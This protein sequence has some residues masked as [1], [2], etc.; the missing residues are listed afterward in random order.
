[1]SPGVNPAGTSSCSVHESILQNKGTDCSLEFISAHANIAPFKNKPVGSF[2]AELYTA[3]SQ[4][5]FCLIKA[6]MRGFLTVLYGTFPPSKT[7]HI[8]TQ[9]PQKELGVADC[10]HAPAAKA[11]RWECSSMEKQK[12]FEAV[13]PD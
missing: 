5:L 1:M 2:G 4:R 3:R 13:N 6:V 11:W 8:D 9:C 7:L 10:F 12:R